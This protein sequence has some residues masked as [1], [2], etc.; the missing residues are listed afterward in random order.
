MTSTVGE[1]QAA[2]GAV[3]DDASGVATGGDG[4]GRETLVREHEGLAR[5]LAARYAW[6]GEQLD[7]LVQVAFIGLLKAIDRYDPA[8]GARLSTYA[9]ATMDGELK[10]Y[11]R[12]H[13]WAMRTPRPLKELYVRAKRSSD[14]L[15][16]E[17]GR[18]PTSA[19]IADDA[20]VSEDE[21]A[22]AW[23]AGRNL[24]PRS[25]D[26]PVQVDGEERSF[27]VGGPDE[28]QERVEDRDELERLLA[29]LPP[30]W[31][32]VV[33]LRFL[34]HLTQ[35]EIA[36][37]VGV[38]Q[39]RVSRILAQSFAQL[40]A[41]GA[42]DRHRRSMSAGVPDV[43]SGPSR[44]VACRV[45][46]G[47]EA[48]RSDQQEPSDGDAAKVPDAAPAAT[49]TGLDHRGRV[50]TRP[51]RGARPGGSAM[52]ERV[53]LV[54]DDDSLRESVTLLCRR[55][56]WHVESEADGKKAVERF[57]AGR[58]DLVLLDLML[59]SL[60]GF[61]VCRAIRKASRVPI[62]ML[63]A[64]TDTTDLVAGLELGADDYVTKPFEAAELVARVRAVLRRV[65]PCPEGGVLVVAGLEINPEAFTV[66]K[67]GR[68]LNLSATEFRLLLELAHHA[69]LVLTREVLLERVWNYDY[70]GDSRLVDMAIKRL[71]DKVEDDPQQP[72][73]ILTVRGVGY[74]FDAGREG[75]GRGAGTAS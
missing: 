45:G 4:P 69:G 11:F 7:D 38:S 1:R 33:R 47:V 56:G 46:N 8:R 36:E 15:T 40:R 42:D 39:A 37:R 62:V 24:R 17:L 70:M 66:H 27:E 14:D 41:A 26:A 73:R 43:L 16:H 65:A 57:T 13:S 31:Q 54:E 35:E 32:H 9:V 60:D 23:D 3:V 67:A 5:S 30:R 10:R 63:T 68:E 34:G 64:R 55:A 52:N 6:R 71:R 61:E 50:G 2:A 74:R 48:G 29:R 59:P 44:P 28:E 72:S 53:L 49:G 18:L 21:L 51:E 12:D 75:H 22:D 58:F 25:L 19:E 20:G